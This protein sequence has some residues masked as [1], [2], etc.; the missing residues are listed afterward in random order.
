MNQQYYL[1][2][3]AG[4][5]TVKYQL[6]GGLDKNLFSLKGNEFQRVTF[7]SDLSIMP[8]KNLTA[9]LGL[10]FTNSV[11]KNNALGEYGAN[12]YQLNPG[13]ALYPYAQFADASGN[14]MPISKNR[15]SGFIDTAGNG[16]LLDWQYR[17]LQELNNQDNT[18]KLNDILIN[19]GINYKLL[20]DLNIQASYQFQRSVGS[21]NR[22][23]NIQTY[24]TRDLINQFT[25]IQGSTVTHII[26]VGGILDKV[27]SASESQNGRLQLN[28]NKIVNGKH[29]IASLFGV[30]IR[31]RSQDNSANRYYGFSENDLSFSPVDYTS[32]YPIYG[33]S[34]SQQVPNFMGIGKV[35]DRFV[36]LFGN[37]AYTFNSKYTFSVSGRKDAAN[38][39][40]VNTNDKWKPFWTI[41][42]SWVISNES[43]FKT[44]AINYLKARTTFGY[45]GNVNN[46]I[47]AFTVIS[48]IPGNANSLNLP[49]ANISTPGNP[50]LSW[51]TV[52]QTNVG[53][54]FSILKNRISGSFDAYRKSSNNLI[55]RAEIDPTTGI[56][57]VYKN[58]ASMIGKGMEVS[59][60]S[61]NINS[62]KIKWST[63][64]GYSYAYNRVTDFRQNTNGIANGD[65][66]TGGLAYGL[67][68][69]PQKGTLPYA[70]FSYRYAG[71]D[72]NTGDP[73]GYLGKNISTD[74]YAIYSES[75]DTSALVNH[76][77]AIPT[78]FGFFNNVVSYKG[79]TLF[80]NINYRLG[81]YF[82]KSTI[83]YYMLDNYGIGH[84][85]YSKRWQNPGDE[86]I[87]NI[88]SR[89][90]PVSDNLRDDFFAYSTENV[91]RGDNIRLQYIKLSYDLSGKKISVKFIRNA[92]L[93]I[94]LS[95]IGIIWRA[96]HEKLDPDFGAGTASYIPPRSIV[97][98]LKIDL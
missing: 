90:Y 18:N 58:S 74:Y 4:N 11:S 61:L 22:Y 33:A 86:K 20:N 81:Y 66:L 54:D 93:Y 27:S 73:Q 28:F 46:L 35:N 65:L 32:Q 96:N 89:I 15:R 84:A 40:G 71:L 37:A 67:D 43:F 26:P 83:N 8:I 85:D 76:G 97:G 48:N 70:I 92:Q 21:E 3:G 31:A 49:F 75:N 25:Q 23:H 59:L 38:V 1:S 41:G 63:Q 39:F 19:L 64:I 12:A 98:G 44:N 30:E 50:D 80:I 69:N 60:T 7:R 56:P 91:L 62:D 45:Q 53:L 2:A 16:L 5:Q 10:F 52:R 9:N 78:S 47:P 77:S 36:S 72:P 82:R 13:I 87:S 79:F 68:L 24:F 51:E 29:Q 6:A 34:Y 95:N 88:P 55:L 42:G 94:T 57:S 17:P 14:A